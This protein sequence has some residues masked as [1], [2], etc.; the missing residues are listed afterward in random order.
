[1][2]PGDFHLL[3][4]TSSAKHRPDA[5]SL[6]HFFRVEKW[7]TVNFLTRYLEV[8]IFEKLCTCLPVFYWSLLFCYFTV[9]EGSPMCANTVFPQ[10]VQIHDFF[11]PLPNVCKHIISFS[12]LPSMCKHIIPPICVNTLLLSSAFYKTWVCTVEFVGSGKWTLHVRGAQD[13]IMLQTLALLEQYW[14]TTFPGD[15]V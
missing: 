12:P 3:F 8:F 2:R 1:M 4:T 6:F 9:Q 11:L 15:V 7:R 14:R 13:T 10:C 5:G